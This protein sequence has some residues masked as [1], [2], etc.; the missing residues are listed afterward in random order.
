VNDLDK[1][2]AG[3]LE[4]VKALPPMSEEQ[5]LEQAIDFTFGNLACSTNHKASREAIAAL[6]WKNAW[7]KIQ[8]HLDENE[9]RKVVDVVKL[10]DETRTLLSK[11]HQK[12]DGLP[13]CALSNCTVCERQKAFREEVQKGIDALSNFLHPIEGL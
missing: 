6:V 12:L 9:L 7:K 8:E 13:G 10:V 2:L 1:E 3:A 4:K 11:C 5:R